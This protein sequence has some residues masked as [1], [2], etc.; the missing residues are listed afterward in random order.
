MFSGVLGGVVG[1]IGFLVLKE[2]AGEHGEGVDVVGGSGG[3]M[4][5]EVGIV[6][7]LEGGDD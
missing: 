2:V 7:V 5:P 3:V 4:L 1:S 6:I